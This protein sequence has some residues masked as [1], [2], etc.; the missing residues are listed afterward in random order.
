MDSKIKA[1]KKIDGEP[2]S[3]VNMLAKT[4]YGQRG[5]VSYMPSRLVEAWAA[6]GLVSPYEAHPKGKPSSSK[7]S[8]DN[9]ISKS[10]GVSDSS[11]TSGKLS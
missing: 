2:Y 3:A 11:P 1:T 5:T 9:T 4:I 7:S 10:S 8:R 6:K